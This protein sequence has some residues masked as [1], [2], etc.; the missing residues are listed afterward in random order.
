M[1]MIIAVYADDLFAIGK[2]SSGGRSGR[3]FDDL[4]PV[5]E[6]WAT[7]MMFG[8]SVRKKFKEGSL[9]FQSSR[10]NSVVNKAGRVF[11]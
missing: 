3:D 1:V 7:A 2:L 8:M 9:K 4:V 5:K 10:L 11:A 6:S